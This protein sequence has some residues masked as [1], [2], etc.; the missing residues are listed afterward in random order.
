MS[1]ELILL[2]MSVKK[3]VIQLEK[4]INLKFPKCHAK[5]YLSRRNF[6]I[7][8]GLGNS[9]FSYTNF[10]KLLEE[11]DLFLKEHLPNKFISN[12]PKFMHSTKWKF[13]YILGTK[14]RSWLKSS[15]I[16]LYQNIFQMIYHGTRKMDLILGVYKINAT[17]F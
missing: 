15:I 3:L 5:F 13:D 12:F 2:K 14:K 1:F 4:H 11:V 16:V 17:I 6:Y 8:M 9:L 10:K 7:H